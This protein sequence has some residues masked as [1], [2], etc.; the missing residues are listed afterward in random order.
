MQSVLAIAIRDIKTNDG[1]K[2]TPQ[3]YTV[4]SFKGFVW[5]S[6]AHFG[7]GD[8]TT[9]ILIVVL[10]VVLIIVGIILCCCCCACCAAANVV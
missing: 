3:L 10:I 6:F 4:E 7:E 8:S 9:T 2:N 1:H 5:N